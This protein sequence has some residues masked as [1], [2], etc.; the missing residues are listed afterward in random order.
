MFEKILLSQL[1][2]I[3]PS[4]CPVITACPFEVNNNN[5]AFVMFSNI[6]QM[7]E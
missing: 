7:E 3:K 5:A 6:R 1:T 2:R 4:V